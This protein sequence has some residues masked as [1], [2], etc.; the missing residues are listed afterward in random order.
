MKNIITPIIISTI[1]IE[2]L[3][4]SGCINL[5]SSSDQAGVYTSDATNVTDSTATL[6]GSLNWN[7]IDQNTIVV[8]EYGTST[9][10]GQTAYVY[11]SN[12]LDNNIVSANL[13]GLTPSTTYHFRLKASNDFGVDVTF[14]TAEKGSNG[15]I[16]NPN[17]IYDS[18]SDYSG[19]TYK[20]IQ[21]GTQTWMAENLKTVQLNDG[22]D[23]RFVTDGSVWQSLSV[24]AYCWYNNEKSIYKPIYGALYNWHTVN[25]AK[26]CP[27]GWHVPTD[28]EWTT[29]I[30]FLGGEFSACIK[31]SETGTAHWQT[32]T[33]ATNESGFTALPGGSQ[34]SSGI[35]YY[36][37]VEGRWWSSTTNDAES[38]FDREI[39]HI[40]SGS[41]NKY[42]SNKVF[43]YSIR[44]VKN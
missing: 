32:N 39:I 11:Q 37:G 42:L 17:L 6:N 3:I 43:G 34:T 20:T 4:L 33:G 28:G 30:S 21:I 35:F 38:A 12:A 15:I 13:K 18:V 25:T 44:C 29:L 26:L 27:E 16:F 8:F 10:Y 19:N 31:L 23:I 14:T 40:N 1:V 22:T 2:A 41:I 7:Y 24:P 5:G 36:I 9:S